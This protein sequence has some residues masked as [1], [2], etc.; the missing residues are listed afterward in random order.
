MQQFTQ[1][2]LGI[3]LLLA[4]RKLYWVFVGAVGFF[5]G[6]FIAPQFFTGD[7]DISVIVVA[8][9]CGILGAIL[10]IAIQ[11][12]GVALA[13]LLVGGYFAGMLSSG[14]NIE[15]AWVSWVI[16]IAGAIVGAVLLAVVFDYALIGLTTLAGAMLLVPALNLDPT[17]S[18]I[19]LIV[20]V[21]LGASVQVAT[22][23]NE[24]AA[25]ARKPIVD[26]EKE[27]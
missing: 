11:R 10:T 8:L 6:L 9:I 23:Q 18:L 22:L 4:G 27:K 2:I 26:R 19:S 25:E 5:A 24:V 17:I 20:A 13:G 16:V 7:S 12:V 15:T 14:L 3:A 21:I 1:I